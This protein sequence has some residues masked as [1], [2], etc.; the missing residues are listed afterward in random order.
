M[1]NQ[2]IRLGAI[3]CSAPLDEGVKRVIGVEA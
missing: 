2:D 3:L 1:S